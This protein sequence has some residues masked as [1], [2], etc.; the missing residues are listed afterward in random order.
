MIQFDFRIFFQMGWNVQPPT[1]Y[2]IWPEYVSWLKK[3]KPPTQPSKVI[4]ID[5]FYKKRQVCAA[6]LAMWMVVLLTARGPRC[7]TGE[8]WRVVELCEKRR[9][10]WKK[11]K[12]WNTQKHTHKLKYTWTIH[13]IKKKTTHFLNLSCNLRWLN[14]SYVCQRLFSA[15][16]GLN[17][18]IVFG[19]DD[20]T[21]RLCS[22][23]DHA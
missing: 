13:E 1:S 23:Q 15:K 7:L 22:W 19:F 20:S 4:Y 10:F 3:T 2:F 6:N 5:V 14:K 9:V 8:G 11:K 17:S 21:N 16:A 18:L 12:T